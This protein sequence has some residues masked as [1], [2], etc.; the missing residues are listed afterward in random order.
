MARKK[1]T[2][3]E[4]T[5][6]KKENKFSKKQILSSKR[7]KERQDAVGAILDDDKKYSI[8]EV[9]QMYEKFM[10]EEVK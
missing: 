4:V 9:E 3:E 5:E 10:K 2:P 6:E 8:E 1:S 7:F